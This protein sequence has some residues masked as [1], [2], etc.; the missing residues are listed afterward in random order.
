MLIL[1][2]SVDRS[3]LSNSWEILESQGWMNIG[4]VNLAFGI[5]WSSAVAYGALYSLSED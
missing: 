3:F 4:F 5:R 2:D 1:K